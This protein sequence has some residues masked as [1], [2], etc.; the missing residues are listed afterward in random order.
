[1]QLL[2]ANT[3][4]QYVI[5][6]TVASHT[7]VLLGTADARSTRQPGDSTTDSKQWDAVQTTPSGETSVPQESVQPLDQ[8]VD[9]GCANSSNARSNGTRQSNPDGQQTD[10]NSGDVTNDA[11]R[12]HRFGRNTLTAENLADVRPPD[13]FRLIEWTVFS[14]WR[15]LVGLGTFEVVVYIVTVTVV[16]VLHSRQKN[17][18]GSFRDGAL[19]SK[20]QFTL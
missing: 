8:R 20:Y 6:L 17:Q 12:D 16:M 9:G 4:M 11:T 3:L 14:D 10:T 7:G 2:A 1:M 13:Q 5:M 15:V 19:T 18:V